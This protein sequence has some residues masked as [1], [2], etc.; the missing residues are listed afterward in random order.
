MITTRQKNL[1]AFIQR[2][3]AENG[4][5]PTY[6][7]IGDACGLSSPSSVRYQMQHLATHGKIRLIQGRH[8]GIILEGDAK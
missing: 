7:E 8:R 4:Y 5:M 3:H 2:F 1:L 6:R